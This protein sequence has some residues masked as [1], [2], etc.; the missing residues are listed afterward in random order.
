MPQI[1]GIAEHCAGDLILMVLQGFGFTFL[2]MLVPLALRPTCVG[3]SS[4]GTF[5]SIRKLALDRICRQFGAIE[6]RRIIDRPAWVN[7]ADERGALLFA[8]SYGLGT[9]KVPEATSWSAQQLELSRDCITS[10]SVYQEIAAAGSTLASIAKVT[11]GAVTGCNRGCSFYPSRKDRPKVFPY[12]MSSP[13]LR[14]LVMFR[15]F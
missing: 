13:A 5:H 1:G 7:G 8:E 15:G 10:S 2:F 12:A 11:I 3:H 4:L 9:S 6:I 14:E